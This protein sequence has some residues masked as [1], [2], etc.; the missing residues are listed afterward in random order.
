MYDIAFLKRS[1]IS[2]E[3]L[4]NLENPKTAVELKKTLNAHRETIS[5]ALLRLESRGFAKCQNPSDKNYRFYLITEKGKELLN[6][7]NKED[8]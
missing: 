6:K 4:E 7:F 2:K 5:R 8:R 3:I 1:K